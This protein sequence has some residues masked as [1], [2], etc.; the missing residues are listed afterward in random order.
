MMTPPTTPAPLGPRF[1]SRLGFLLATVGS[2]V[3]L[4]NIW[5]FP[6][7]TGE[8]GGG[9]FLLPYVLAVAVVGLPVM[10]IEIAA[11]RATGQGVVGTFAAVAPRG[12]WLGLLLALTT[13]SLLSYYLV[14]TGWTLGYLL[15]SLG[16]TH[17]SFMRFTAGVHSLWGFLLAT[18][19]TVTIVC[20]GVNRG[21]EASSKVLMPALVLVLVGLAVYSLTLPGRTAALQFYL[22]PRVAAIG[23]PVVWIRALGQAF[24]SVGVGMG[25]LI[26]Y[27]AYVA[28]GTP[29]VR[30]AMV[31]AG[32]DIGIALLAGL[33]IFPIAFTFERAPGSGPQLAFE[34][35]PQAFVRLP[36][37]VGYAVAVLF[38]F[39][40]SVA[41]LTSAVSLL[42]TVVI[43]IRDIMGLTRRRALPVGAV[44]LTVLGLP[45]AL[46]YSGYHWRI[47]GQP[48]LDLM[49]T[50]VG[51]FGLSV[52]V[53][54]T[55]VM[56]SWLGTAAVTRG[57]ETPGRANKVML[58]LA[59]WVVPVTI[60]LLFGA[61]A[62]DLLRHRILPQG[63]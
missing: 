18:G 12:R 17:P 11:G 29:L 30:S 33:V 43:S 56:L 14:V 58:W 37:V 48:V 54:L 3:G 2:A 44:A 13:L 24:F 46:S 52:G 34:T 31:V 55:A 57:L 49:D 60:A 6:F 4:G 19:I 28:P 51:T 40:L 26:T 63:G 7:V 41:A 1:G 22:A 62:V 35:L 45:S 9:A 15:Y 8:N 25:V 21:V 61:M 50:V 5:R 39:A 23:D 10:V 16:N 38:Y 53:C 47:F 27:G 59:R 20:L 36:P 32:A 42:E